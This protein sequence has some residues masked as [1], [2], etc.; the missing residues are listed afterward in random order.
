MIAEGVENEQQLELLKSWGC[1]SAQGFYF[2]KPMPT[3]DVT[4]LL[5]RGKIDRVGR[6]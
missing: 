5:R 1:R 2:A 3:E 6:H 4:P